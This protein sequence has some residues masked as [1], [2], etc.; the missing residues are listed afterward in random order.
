MRE[1]L[2]ETLRTLSGEELLRFQTASQAAFDVWQIG[3]AQ[4][5]AVLEA[6]L[7]AAMERLN[8]A[9]ERMGTQFTQTGRDATAAFSAI[10]ENANATSQ[11]I[12]T[13]FRA[14]LSKVATVDE[15]RV[16]GDLLRSAGEQ[17][18]IGFDQTARAMQLVDARIRS[19]TAAVDPLV[20]EFAL[21]G[22][23]SQAS[24]NAAKD[25]AYDAF[26]AIRR[27]AA[28]GKASVEDVRRAFEAYARTARAT[29]ADSDAAARDHC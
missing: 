4:A 12:E 19:I 6:T 5:A 27:G 24:L 29:V 10:L 16:L 20:D 8:V 17:G 15:V 3:P 18:A 23:Q 28:S 22:I 25:A 11:Q 21:L 7:V 2:L 14:A 26:D 1:G 9:A 13:A